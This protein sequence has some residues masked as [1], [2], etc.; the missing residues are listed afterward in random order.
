MLRFLLLILPISL[1]AFPL[2]FELNQGQFPSPVCFS[3]RGVMFSANGPRFP[4]GTRMT[5]AGGRASAPE[6]GAPAG[7]ISYF[8]GHDPAGWRFGVPQVGE[9]RYREVYSGIDLLFHGSAGKLE[10]DFQ[11]RPGA[12]PH[13]IR[14][15]FHGAG[16]VTLEG[17]DL[18]V[19]SLR[20]HRPA[21]FQETAA[22]RRG[23]AV[24]YRL[25]DGEVR[26]ELGPY[27]RELPL[28]IDPALSY[29]TYAGGSGNDT[30]NAIAV[31]AA[32]N[33]YLAGNSDSPD[34]PALKGVAINARH[35][36]VARL[37]SSGANFTSIAAIG[38]ASIEGVALDS[39]GNP[40]VT[41]SITDAAQFPGATSGAYQAGAAGFVAR[42]TLDA[43]GFKPAF[44][45]T[46]AATP[47]AVALDPK[48]F[49]YVTGSAG[50]AFRTTTGALQA[51]S[52]GGPSDGFVLKL[53]SD[54]A[55]ALYATY[56]GGKAEDAA[57]A[58]A[59]NTGGEAYIAGDTASSDFPITPGAAQATFG[60]RLLDAFGEVAYGDAFAAKL[61][62]SGGHLVFSTYLGG[63]AADAA[64]G[65]ALDSSGNA[66][67][68]GGTQSADFPATAGVVQA[69]YAGGT[70]VRV[71]A[72]PAGDAFVSKLSATGVRLWSTFLG[73]SARDIAEAIAVDPVGNVVVAGS[74]DSAD[75]PR[76]AGALSGCRSGGPWVAQVNGAGVKLLVS[77]SLPGL[78][79]DEPR[80][81]A[82]DSKGMVYLAGSVSSRVFFATST[83]AQ[84]A[85]GGGDSDAFAAR[86]DLGASG[87]L[88]VAC[89][90][91]AASYQAGNFSS[92]PTGTV[93][94]GEIVSV[95]GIGLGPD[96]PVVPVVA[97]GSGAAYPTMLG[98]A[99]V[100]FDGVPA[101]LLYVSANQINAV[102][103]YGI[104]SPVTQVTVQRGGISDGPRALPVAPA[105]P[106]IFTANSAG[107]GQAAAL[108]EDGSYNS[109]A[110]PAAGGSMVV[111]YVVGGGMMNSPVAD[112]SVS[113]NALPL[114][115]PQLPVT[116]QIRG[117]EVDPS[118]AGS[119]PGYVSG[120]LQINVRVPASI[121]FGSSVPLTVLVGGQASQF[122]V[123]IAVK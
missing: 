56:V 11:L 86:L 119:A 82:L 74:S 118:Y 26:F 89:V 49:I 44:I 27:D 50:T 54:G 24:R 23:V 75:F 105:V 69:T 92:F 112:G 15:R 25:H 91:N 110:N 40:V 5:L 67:V 47:F 30:G 10:Y 81:L 93:A 53:S 22:G 97:R 79:L 99:Q 16:R 14:L 78:G 52:G 34:F 88:S 55:R 64:Y 57:R 35:G 96:Q 108:N 45:A 111:F 106:A 80:A 4:G 59:V 20:Q 107:S 102:V 51:S 32:G 33:S 17:E 84:A 66:Y 41:G 109:A 90:V 117:V 9:I 8:A 48:D 65:I 72:D 1:S 94:P 98:G 36:F 2:R 37:D 60:G 122:N 46:F 42:F 104:K 100:L 83:A 123:T 28:V 121:G 120:L 38:G 73:G 62:A 58:I 21:A 116:A 70:P 113:G 13:A 63:K 7:R 39:S 115:A 77:T 31:D 12:D 87:R 6:A 61:D 29:A 95:F 43:A 19:G 3:A 76:T 71:D 103:P 18:V 114:P 85:Y 68:T 101:P